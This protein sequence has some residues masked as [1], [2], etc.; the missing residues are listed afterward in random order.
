MHVESGF[1]E[2]MAGDR[3][4]QKGATEEKAGSDF[5]IVVEDGALGRPEIAEDLVESIFPTS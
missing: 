5:F 1:K 3:R 4:G 2:G